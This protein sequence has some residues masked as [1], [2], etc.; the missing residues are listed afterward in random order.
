M[1]FGT[2]TT[3]L[4]IFIA[5]ISLA[6]GLVVAMKTQVDKT[7]NSLIT[8]QE[9]L[10]GSLE[11]EI[12]I[13]VIWHNTTL[14]RTKVYVRNIGDALIKISKVDVFTDDGWIPRNVGNR[15]IEVLNDTDT[16]NIGVWDPGE[17]VLIIINQTLSS[18]VSHTIKVS[19]DNGVTDEEEF[20]I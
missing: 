14:N 7:T 5:A 18:T 6:T 1:A 16:V 3:H 8:Q 17:E 10:T 12:K 11:T 19:T 9:R 4:I 2:L 13:E 15:T 20:S